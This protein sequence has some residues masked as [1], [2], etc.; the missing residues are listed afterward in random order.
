MNNKVLRLIGVLF[1]VA[2]MMGFGIPK[3]VQKKVDKAVTS[4][5]E[6]E[7]FTMRP[8][9]VPSS[10]NINLPCKITGENLFQLFDG[11]SPIGYIFIEQAPSKTANFDYMILMDDNFKILHS[12]VLIYR[13]EYGGEIGSKRWLK[14]FIGKTPGDRV[15]H[16][17]NIDGIAGATIS[18]RSMT[19]AIDSLLQ[20]VAI[21]QANKVL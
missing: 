11:Q 17:T 9:T 12:K 1:V 13:E 8:I 16:K 14:Q 7:A 15:D 21:L 2:V 6:I 5:F 10:V 18:V 3:N 19:S 4:Y 20:T